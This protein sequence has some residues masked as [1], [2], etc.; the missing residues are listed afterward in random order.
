MGVRYSSFG[1]S[2]YSLRVNG[3][4]NSYFVNSND[5]AYVFDPSTQRLSDT[6]IDEMNTVLTNSGNLAKDYIL[7]V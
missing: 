3:I 5:L 4:L 2:Y 1:G 7:K 6:I